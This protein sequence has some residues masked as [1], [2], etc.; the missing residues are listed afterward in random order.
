MNS[1][2]IIG[3]ADGPTAIFL[4]GKSG[5]GW[6]NIW[7]LIL[8]VLLLIPNIIYA[9]KMKHQKNQCTNKVMNILE[10][11]GRFGCMFCMVFNIGKD[12]M[13]FGSVEAFLIY[14]FGNVV[15]ITA[16]WTIWM[17]YFYKQSYWKQIALAVLP[18]CLFL[19]TGITMQY[20]V[21]IMFGFIF[22]IGHIYVT[23]K[24]RVDENR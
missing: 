17:L 5:F 3:G 8:V 2:A 24:N 18:T 9:V 1:V 22:G 13:S 12:E 15:L 11:V 19:L 23:S 16:Y 6:F 21:L 7:G 14:V 10:Q 20:Y 4:A